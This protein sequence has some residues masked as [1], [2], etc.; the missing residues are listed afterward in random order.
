MIACKARSRLL[1]SKDV[2]SV[3]R[4]S[5]VETLSTLAATGSVKQDHLQ[6]VTDKK[7]K[8]FR[9]EKENMMVI[10]KHYYECYGWSYSV[11]D[12]SRFKMGW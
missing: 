8:L 10:F 3:G 11:K 4:S 12:V 7:L 2:E 1:L 6:Y 9:D 5:Y